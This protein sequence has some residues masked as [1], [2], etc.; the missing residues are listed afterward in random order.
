MRITWRLASRLSVITLALLVVIILAVWGLRNNIVG[1]TTNQGASSLSGTD[2]GSTPAPDFHLTDQYG[3]KISLSQFRG[4][5][6][7]LTFM[8]TRCPDV[9]PLTAEKLHS[10]QTMLGKNASHVEMLAVSVDPAH[11][12]QAAALT[13]SQ[14]HRL[15]TNWH[16]LIGTQDELAPV[17]S[18]YSIYAQPTA[19]T[20][21]SMHSAAI[22]VIDQQGHERV[23]MDDDFATNDMLNNLKILLNG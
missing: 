23:L 14:E 22:Y 2:L 12:T 7:L 11:D 19:T 21:G 17:W 18:A 8:Y 3:Q 1:A 4:D 9:C 5:V 16:F 20:G 10:V 13:F 15:T 6:V